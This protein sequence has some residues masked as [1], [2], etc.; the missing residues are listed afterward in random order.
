MQ[1]EKLKKI[2]Q[3]KELEYG[4]FDSNMTNIGRMWSSLLGIKEDIPGWLVSN[5]YVAAKL[6]RTKTKF[7]K[8]TYD[9]AEN[10]LYQ[11]KLMQEKDAGIHRDWLTGYKKWKKE[12]NDG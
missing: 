12:K 10:Y 1:N 4:S 11:A 9:D 7:K 8:D 6:I 3:A 5:M 2:R